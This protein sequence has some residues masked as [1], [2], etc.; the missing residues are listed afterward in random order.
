MSL[1]IKVSGYFELLYNERVSEADAYRINAFWDHCEN[2]G[3]E[4]W[5]GKV[6]P[7][8][9]IPW[10]YPDRANL[11]AHAKQNNLWH[12]H[13]GAPEWKPS[14]NPD[15]T[16]LVSEWVIHFQNFSDQG[17]IKLVDLG[18]HDPFRLPDAAEI[19]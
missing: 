10:D 19:E 5:R 7:S 14:R 18:H 4:G 12:A 13:F 16:Y 1:E 11:V 15:A 2:F 8:W 9:E 17:F 6:K 3:L